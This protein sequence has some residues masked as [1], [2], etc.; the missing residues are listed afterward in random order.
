M[1]KISKKKKDQIRNIVLKFA[2]ENPNADGML[3]D[4]DGDY[5]NC[6]RKG[7]ERYWI[8]VRPGDYIEV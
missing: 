1:K 7:G 2:R 3:I 4:I 5:F 6:F 8:I